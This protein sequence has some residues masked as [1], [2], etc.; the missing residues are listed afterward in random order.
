MNDGIYFD[1]PEDE[2]RALPRLSA[3][4][5]CNML[6]SPATFWANS[7]MNPDRVDDDTV[8]RQIGRAYHC[9]RFEPDRFEARYVRQIVRED[10]PDALGTDAEIKAALKDAGEPQTKAGEGVLARAHRLVESGFGGEVWHLH[11]ED[12]EG[13][14]GDRIALP[15][16]VW[17][18]IHRDA[19]RLRKMPEVA[20][21]LT[22]GCGEVSVLWT[23]AETGIP[24]KC[25]FDYLRPTGVTDFKTFENARGTPVEQA[26][27]NA[28]R[29]NRYYVQA[30]LYWRVAETVRAGEVEAVDATAEQQALIDAIRAREVPM[31]YWFVFQ[32]KKGIPN[33][34][35]R[36][37][38]LIE[39][40][41]SLEI[42]ATD[43]GAAERM[44]SRYGGM[45]MIHRK[46]EAEIN[47]AKR[48][49][50]MMLE[51]YGDK[52]DPWFPINGT[53][54]IDD[55]CYSLNWL[56]GDW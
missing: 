38:A 31:E 52:G 14:R 1:L 29:F 2:Y 18:D 10:F 43:D 42:A 41:R 26:M 55:E 53:G 12:F 27:V 30:A 48:Q 25:R 8:A 20:E 35:A 56:E 4:G 15:P 49:Y 46:A 50:L 40:H 22:G 9:A 51:I 7:W 37:L 19:E 28:V 23:C 33:I 47:Y 13:W 24:M 44:H 36:Q 11:L 16:N 6:A 5:I 39:M 17:D 34:F 21:H 3:T 32:E 45:T 54:R